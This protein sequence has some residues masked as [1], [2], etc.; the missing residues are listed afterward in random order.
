MMYITFH[1][2]DDHDQMQLTEEDLLGFPKEV[3]RVFSGQI[4]ERFKGSALTVKT[5]IAGQFAATGQ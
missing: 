4:T 2:Y 3:L 5:D 1:E